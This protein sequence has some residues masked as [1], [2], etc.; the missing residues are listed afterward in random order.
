ME[1]DIN[2]LAYGIAA[3]S[4]LETLIPKILDRQL[5]SETELLDIF[6]HVAKTQ[7]LHGVEFNNDADSAASRLAGRLANVVRQHR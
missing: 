3:F 7:A 4:I 2:P 6:E 5:L 1:R